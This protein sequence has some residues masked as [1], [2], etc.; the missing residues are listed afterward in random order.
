MS[1]ENMFC[2][3]LDSLLRT[4]TDRIDFHDLHHRFLDF[5]PW[6]LYVISRLS[7]RWLVVFRSRSLN[8]ST[9]FFSSSTID[10]ALTSTLPLHHN[11]YL[12]SSFAYAP[13][14]SDPR[15]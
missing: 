5:S 3:A 6:L 8:M 7:Q 12:L 14:H 1:A 15:S 9:L 10:V 4:L 2:F 11:L 13:Y